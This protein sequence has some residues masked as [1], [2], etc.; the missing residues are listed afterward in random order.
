MPFGLKNA[1]ATFQR[2]MNNV[3][4]GLI[5]KVCLVYMD[6]IIIYGKGLTEHLENLRRVFKRLRDANLKIQ[7]DK[8]EFL[9]T[10]TKFLG[11]IVTAEG[12]KPDP[13]KIDAI[14]N[15]KIPTNTTQIKSFLG[16]TGYYRKF[17][18][19]YAKLAKPLTNCLKKGTKI[20]HNSAFVNS[21]ESLKNCITN[22]P[23]LQY[24][25]FNKTFHITVDA[26]KFVLGAVLSQGT[27]GQDKPIAFASRTLNNSEL[28]YSTIEKKCLAVVWAVQ[29]FRPYVFGRKFNIITDHKSLLWLFNLKEPNSKLVRWRL[30]LEEYTYTILHKQRK[31]NK[32]ADGLSRMFNPECLNAIETYNSQDDQN[33]V[34]SVNVNVGEDSESSMSYGIDQDSKSLQT[35][36]TQNEN[37]DSNLAISETPI[38]KFSKQIILISMPLNEGEFCKLVKQ[39]VPHRNIIRKTFALN[40]QNLLHSIYE[41]LKHFCK[42]NQPIRIHS[43]IDKV[44]EKLSLAIQQFRNLNIT[45]YTQILDDIAGEDDQLE[46]IKIYHEGKTNHRGIDVT[47]RTLS[48]RYYFPKMLEKVNRHINNW[49][50]CQNSK[51]DRHP[52]N[53]LLSLTDTPTK[54]FEIIHMDI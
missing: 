22:F 10:E 1:P 32:N 15:F 21:F 8:S 35:Q 12:I 44:S 28:N 25:D 47:Y 9:K 13:S 18:N 43:K 34:R 45:L 37:I 11:H 27:I 51:Y 20:E 23:I 40:N 46:F 14:Q 48:A 54:A 24:P 31:L 7:L 5:R 30:K 42:S 33:S 16:I 53:P 3:L 17:I 26:S 49:E 38:N 4:N 52:P 29:H 19:N 41:F 39:E 50:L 2:L 6:D 36:H